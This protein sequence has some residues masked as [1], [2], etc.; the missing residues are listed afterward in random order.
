MYT[1]EIAN[2]ARTTNS[3]RIASCNKNVVANFCLNVIKNMFNRNCLNNSKRVC[4]NRKSNKK[5]YWNNK[6]P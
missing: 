4:N 5:F 2:L 6:T 1:G 3:T